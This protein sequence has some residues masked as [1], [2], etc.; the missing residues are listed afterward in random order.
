MGRDKAGLAFGHETLLQR[1]LRLVGAVTADIVVAAAAA[2]LVPASVKVS[3]DRAGSEG[4]LPAVLAALDVLDTTHVF[5]V[6]CDTPLLQ[7]A[8]LP[9]LHELCIGW[10]AAV[11]LLDG[12]PVPTCA[13]YRR[14]ALVD[15]REGFGDPRHR[16]LRDFIALLRI[17]EIPAALIQ[18]VD[19]T[20]SSFTPCNT[21]EEYRQALALAGIPV[22]G[23]PSRA[24]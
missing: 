19:P 11:P 20:L 17:R 16:S 7:P 12:W 24:V 6:A 18:T 2:Q 21:P 1:M 5:L 4:P 23:P 13:V 22:N 8:L 3:R 15:A 14:S 9:F 10:D